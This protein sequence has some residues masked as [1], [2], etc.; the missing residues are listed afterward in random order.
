[1]IVDGKGSTLRSFKYS[2]VLIGTTALTCV[3]LTGTAQAA[4]FTITATD[5]TTNGNVAPNDINGDDTVSARIALTATGS[6][7]GIATCNG[8][9]IITVSETGS[10]TTGAGNNA[11]GIINHGNF[12]TTTF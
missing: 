5:N 10:I 3:F 4:D 2:S 6:A 9:N 7:N 11:H 8:T 1:M 12:N